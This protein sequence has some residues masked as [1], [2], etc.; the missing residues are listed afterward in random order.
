MLRATDQDNVFKLELSCW[1]TTGREEGAELFAIC[2]DLD[3]AEVIHDIK[4]FD[5]PNLQ[6]A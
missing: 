1:L 3:S 4:V 2:V 5:V 6:K